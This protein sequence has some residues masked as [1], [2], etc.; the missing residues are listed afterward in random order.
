[1]SGQ[2]LLKTIKELLD[3]NGIDISHCRGQ[4]YDGGGVVAGKN[5][6]LTAHF[7]RINSKVL[8]THCSCHR[9][10]LA[11]V[12]SCGEQRI[13]NLMTNVKKISYFFN[14]SV[15]QNNCLKEK[16]L[17]FCPDSSKHKLKDVCR[18]RRVEK[19]ERMDVFEDLLVPVYHSLLTMKEDNDIVHYNNETSAKAESLFKLIDDL[20]F[21]ITL[22]ITRSILDYLL[23]ETW[24]LQSKDLDVAKLA[25]IISSLKSSIQNLRI[26]VDKYHS[27][28]YNDA[29]NLSEKIDIK[30]SIS[31]L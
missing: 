8:Y 26:S 12:T 11:V 5:Q 29:L 23:P 24:K 4:G 16:T 7:L 27:K 15:P 19:I 31:Y 28:W 13:R 25:G 3:S 6:G 17:Q 2:S 21:I 1:M 9:L 22:V 14:L 18:T 30:E 10:N 20:E